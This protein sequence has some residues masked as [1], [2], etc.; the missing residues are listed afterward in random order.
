MPARARLGFHNIF[1]SLW[2]MAITTS[3][4]RNGPNP[5]TLFPAL[6]TLFQ[7]FVAKK[8]AGS[9]EGVLFLYLEVVYVANQETDLKGIRLFS[10]AITDSASGAG[11]ESARAPKKVTASDLICA[12]FVGLTELKCLNPDCVLDRR[13]RDESDQGDS[14]I[15]EGF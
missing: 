10:R 13:H 8:L 3:L 14:G 1:H 12:L 6:Q 5:T 4:E 9:K 15:D 7:S 11:A 2:K